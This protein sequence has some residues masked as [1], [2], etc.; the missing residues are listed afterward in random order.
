MCTEKMEFLEKREFCHLATICLWRLAYWIELDNVAFL[1]EN[2]YI[3]FSIFKHQRWTILSSSGMWKTVIGNL[4]TKLCCYKIPKRENTTEHELGETSD[5]CIQC[6]IHKGKKFAFEY[7]ATKYRRNLLSSYRKF[8]Q[9]FDGE[10]KRQWKGPK[11]RLVKKWS[12]DNSLGFLFTEW[13]KRN[14]WYNFTT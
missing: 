5:S 11:L 9:L 7:G 1:N 10:R 6:S 4:R 8:E 13:K 3:Y 12:F 14:A 2:R